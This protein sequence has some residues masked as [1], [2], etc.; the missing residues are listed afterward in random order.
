MK[1]TAV[2]ILNYRA[3]RETEKCIESI[4]G[5]N[6][7][8]A[9]IVVVDNASDN[10]SFP[11]L[12]RKYR[13]NEKIKVIRNR[14]NQGFARGNNLG[15]KIAVREWK[16]EFI[17]LLNSDTV[18]LESDYLEKILGGYK[19]GVGVLQTN[20]LRLNGRYTQKSCGSFDLGALCLEALCNFF[21]Y[22]NLYIPRWLKKSSDHFL[23]PW[24]SGCD[25]MLTP[26]YLKI[27]R[28]LYPGTFLY[29][30]EHI[31]A[32]I[33]K[34]AGLEWKIIEDAHILHAESKSTP[35][36]FREG[37]LKKRKM[38]LIADRN[39]LFVRIMP[40]RVLRYLINSG[41]WHAGVDE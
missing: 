13:K 3:Y 15:I 1:K 24:V 36:D 28:G 29:G 35:A 30:E 16:A 22:Y 41:K 23:E 7:R 17:L 2:V 6:L 32:T 20:A 25:I 5:K 19:P 34:K 4:I 18:I 12:A 11:Y 37:T 33:L 39:K 26:D 40:L 8:V 21:S 14:K 10:E 9:G 31:L 38:M 27:F